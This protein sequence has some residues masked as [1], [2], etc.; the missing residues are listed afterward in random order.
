VSVWLTQWLCARRHCALAAAW[1]SHE[2]T[3]AEVEAR[4]LPNWLNPWCGMCGGALRPE[5][6]ATVFATM[7]DARAAFDQ[8]QAA[9]LAA[10]REMDRLGLTHDVQRRRG[11]LPE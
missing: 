11:P 6:A 7:A 3:A 9:Q 10:R 8:V 2:T 1:E 4:P 5:S